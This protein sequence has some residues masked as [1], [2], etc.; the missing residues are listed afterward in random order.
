MNRKLEHQPLLFA[1]FGEESQTSGNGLTGHPVNERLSTNTNTTTIREIGPKD[2]A[3]QLRPSGAHQTRNPK[4]LPGTNFEAHRLEHTL[5]G[6]VFHLE[7][8]I[9]QGH[10]AFWNLFDDGPADHHL[11]QLADGSP[12]HSPRSDR[13]S[14]SH[15]GDAIAD[16]KNLLHSVRDVDDRHPLAAQ[17]SDHTKERLDLVVGQGSRRL[18]HDQEPRLFSEGAGDLD[19]LLLGNRQLCNRSVRIH[20]AT[21]PVQEIAGDP[22]HDIAPD[23]TPSGGFMAQEDVLGHG[24]TGHQIELLVN[25]DEP[26]ALSFHRALGRDGM[27]RKADGPGVRLILPTQHLHEGRFAGAVLTQQHVD[28][29][30]GHFQ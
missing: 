27:P 1:I 13:V 8:R 17:G 15:H 3:S 11:N 28:L 14:V 29:T 30:G 24:Q 21:E 26:G 9:P 18:V 12:L 25:H 16:G 6:Q 2:S 10:L 19:Q 7:N 20:L 23:Q 4:D 22:T 5:S